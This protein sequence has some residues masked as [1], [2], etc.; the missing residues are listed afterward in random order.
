M[1]GT[2]REDGL[3]QVKMH[4][5]ESTFPVLLGHD[6]LPELVGELKTLDM[7]KVTADASYRSLCFDAA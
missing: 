2:L 5:G 7:D 6:K 4:I 1:D 3:R